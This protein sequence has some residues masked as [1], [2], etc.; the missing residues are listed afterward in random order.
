MSE[1]CTSRQRQHHEILHV[2][3]RRSGTAKISIVAT[4]ILP[5]APIRVALDASGRR[6][7]AGGHL[8]KN[9]G[10]R[11]N[12][13]RRYRRGILGRVCRHLDGS[14]RARDLRV[15]RMQASK[16]KLRTN[17]VQNPA[18]A[19]ESRRASAFLGYARY[20]RPLGSAVLSS[21]LTLPP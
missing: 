17:F 14:T 5:H 21:S 20:I 19:L 16:R 6:A 2:L 10:R 18:S 8:V 12:D 4:K 9:S 3:R 1:S 13:S 15:G 7:N 11:R